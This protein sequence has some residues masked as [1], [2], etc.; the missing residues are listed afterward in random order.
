M[1]SFCHFDCLIF[2][3]KLLQNTACFPRQPFKTNILVAQS[4]KNKAIIDGLSP[5]PDK[6]LVC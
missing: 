4:M 1:D 6:E 5:F 3:G 2:D